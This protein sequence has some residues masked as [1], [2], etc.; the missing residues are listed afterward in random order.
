MY[1]TSI[2]ARAARLVLDL[3]EAFGAGIAPRRSGEGEAH[4]RSLAGLADH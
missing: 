2:S 3:S 1:F 4:E